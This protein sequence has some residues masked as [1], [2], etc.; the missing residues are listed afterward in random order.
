L[1]LPRMLKEANPAYRTA[2]FGKWDMRTDEVTPEQMGYDVSDG[3]TGNGTGGSKGSGGPAAKDDP[4]RIFGITDRACNFMEKQTKSGHP[5]FL[6]VSH[7][8]VHLDIYY[9]KKT[10]AQ[11]QQQP[12]GKKHTMP[13]FAAMTRDVDQGIGL[14]LDKI[15]SLGIEEKTYIF[16]LSDNGGRLTMPGQKGKELPRNHP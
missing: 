14:L 11:V 6:Q 8:A 3:Y 15:K 9:Q 13:Q 4:K 2:H 7:Y 16:F 12:R 1:S 5:F 10:L